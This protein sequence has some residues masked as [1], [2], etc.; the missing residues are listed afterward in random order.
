MTHL[1]ASRVS[2]KQLCFS[3]VPLG[4][5]VVRHLLHT[6]VY[7]Y[8]S[9]HTSLVS[10]S[11]QISSSHFPTSELFFGSDAYRALQLK[12]EE[13]EEEEGEKVPA[14]EI[15]L[16]VIWQVSLM[17]SSGRRE[18]SEIRRKG[19][20][21]RRRKGEGLEYCAQLCYYSLLEFTGLYPRG[22]L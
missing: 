17:C 19:N 2:Q 5:T 14:E 8:T 22:G 1:K 4:Q 10:L 15:A 16:I 12:E 6:T 20:Y 7:T 9:C 3:D 18:D 11:S 21:M 13:K